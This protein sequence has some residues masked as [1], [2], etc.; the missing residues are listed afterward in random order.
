MC[1][2]HMEETDGVQ[3]THCR[4]GHEY[5]QPELPRFSVDGYCLETNTVYEVFGCFG[6]GI[7][8]SH[9]GMS[10]NLAVKLW[11]SDMNAPCRV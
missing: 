10:P 1:L 7:R 5:R 2:L 6:T 11:P 9:S 3:I 8:A 4:K